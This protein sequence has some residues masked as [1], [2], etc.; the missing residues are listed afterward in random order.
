MQEFQ[1]GMQK[2]IR[3]FFLKFSKSADF[4]AIRASFATVQQRWVRLLCLE[5]PSHVDMN[6]SCFAGLGVRRSG[7]RISAGQT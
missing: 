5:F 3:A 4:R 1:I 2:R 6:K 7:A